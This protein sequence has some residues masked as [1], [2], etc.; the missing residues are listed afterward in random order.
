MEK[1]SYNDKTDY[2][3]IRKDYG[4]NAF[5]D[6]EARVLKWVIENRLTEPERIIIVLYAELGNLRALVPYLGV[7]LT[8]VHKKVKGVQRKIRDEVAKA[9]K[10]GRI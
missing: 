2:R 4:F 9:I 7:S 10:E 5:D 6:G 3:E 8:A 1:G